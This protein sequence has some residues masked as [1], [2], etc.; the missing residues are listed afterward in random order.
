MRTSRNCRL[1]LR[2]LKRRARAR[3]PEI[4]LPVIKLKRISKRRSRRLKNSRTLPTE[5]SK[6]GTR[7][8]PKHQPPESRKMMPDS[9][10]WKTALQLRRRLKKTPRKPSMTLRRPS[11][12]ALVP[13]KRRLP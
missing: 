8:S 7:S 12:K 6:K 11:M 4:R 9:K 13:K 2:K 3:T 10:Y 5:N 1:T